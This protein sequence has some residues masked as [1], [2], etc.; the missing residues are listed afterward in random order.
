MKEQTA[1]K[2]PQIRFKGFEGEWVEK[3]LQC[4]AGR[5][6][7]LRIPVTANNRIPGNTP[8]YGANGIQDHVQGYTHEGEFILVAEDGANDLKK[9]PVQ[10]VSGK[11][12]VNN[13]AHVLQGKEG[14]AETRFLKYAFSQINVEE[15]LVGGGR[16]KLNA[17]TMMQLKLCAPTDFAEQQK[18][19]RLFLEL[20]RLIGLHQ[21]KHDKLVTLKKAMLQKMFPQPGA[22]TSEIRFKG[23]SGDWVEKRLN[24]ICEIVGGGT[25]STSIQE[26][27]GGD[28][29][30]YS[31]TEIGDE[32]YACGSV[33]KITRL[34]LSKSSARL[35]PPGKTVL[36]T[37]RAGIGDMAILTKE[38]CT[39]QGFQSMVLNEDTDPYFIFSMGHLIK[40]HALKHASGSTFL[41]VSSKH[42]G[43]MKILLPKKN[44]QQKIGTYFR[45]LDELISKYATQLK[46]LQQIKS[47]CLEKMFV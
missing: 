5:Y 41:E 17:E 47:A 20:D 6:D 4:L 14:L 11:I 32:V 3:Q 23:F 13:H 31:P 36:F 37:S 12:W 21:R 16:A 24:E 34:G 35:L 18:I 30:W 29:D 22:T 39:N 42:L 45:T 33:K 7:N 15:F 2:V 46:K 28:I 9:Y 8:Y 1:S 25:P 10:Y 27:W 43:K 19:G 40:M 38:G 26:Y 44:E